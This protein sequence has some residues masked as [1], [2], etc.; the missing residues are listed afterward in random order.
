MAAYYND[1]DP[2]VAQWLRNLIKEGLIADGDVDDRSIGDVQPGDLRGY[3]QCHFFAGIGGWSLALRMA[4]WEDDREVWTGSC[5]CQPIS[6]IGK[7]LAEKDERHLWPEN[8]RLIKA[9]RPSVVFGEQV[10]GKLASKW[11]SNVR[12]DLEADDY[13]FGAADLPVISID[14]RHI[15]RRFYYCAHANE[16]RRPNAQGLSTTKAFAKIRSSAGMVRSVQDGALYRPTEPD[17]SWVVNGLSGEGFAVGA[18]G[19]AIHPPI[20]AEF[21]KAFAECRP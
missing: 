10:T 5:P 1:N 6:V 12:A 2:F 15:R 21:I 17:S 20:A 8:H 7:K 3:T 16:A 19:N 18:F 4:G 9:I 13:A 11:L 14:P